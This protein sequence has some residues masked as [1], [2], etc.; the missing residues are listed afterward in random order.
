VDIDAD[1]TPLEAGLERFVA[2]DKGDFIGRDAL[3]RGRDPELAL[4]A[5]ALDGDGLHP[6]GGEA[7][8][9]RGNVVGYV[10]AG[11]YGH[12]VGHAIALAYLPRR[13]LEAGATF[14]VEVLGERLNAVA[15]F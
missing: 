10:S 1:H 13:L 8:L 12:C 6:H 3:A 11:G 15:G 14:E 7:V 5:L 9:V 2:M 4:A